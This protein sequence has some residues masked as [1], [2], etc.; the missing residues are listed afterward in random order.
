MKLTKDQIQK[1]ALGLMMTAGLIYS[2]IEFLLGPLETSKAA[3]L[4]TAEALQPQIMAAKAQI[5]KTTGL[6]HDGPKAR[7][8]A[9]QVLATMPEG[10][11]VAWFPPRVADFCKDRGME[12]VTTRLN[13]EI[14]EKE[15]VRFRSLNWNIEI[16]K[17]D[18]MTFAAALSE[19]ENTEPLLDINSISIET[20]R[21][22]VG[23]QRVVLIVRNL[24][25]L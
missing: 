25:R 6:S 2:F 18:F 8:L 12:R 21:E 23:H 11:P 3:A 15:L 22:D 16:P 13:Y 14:V 5:A 1:L 24:V 10:S 17:A 19:L 20:T 7:E 4:K 9:A